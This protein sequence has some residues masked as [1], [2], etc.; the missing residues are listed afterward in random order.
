MNARTQELSDELAFAKVDFFYQIEPFSKNEEIFYEVRS[1]FPLELKSDKKENFV[2]ITKN[3]TTQDNALKEYSYLLR[4]EDFQ[5]I[6]RKYK[7]AEYKSFCEI[8]YKKTYFTKNEIKAGK[9]YKLIRD[10]AII[11]V[12][13]FVPEYPEFSNLEEKQEIYCN[14]YLYDKEKCAYRFTISKNKNFERSF[15]EGE[16]FLPC[17][18]G[19]FEIALKQIKERDGLLENFEKNNKDSF[20]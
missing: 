2:P 6:K 20:F 13:T 1:I 11:Y 4:D 16:K 7:G 12:E 5:Y 3:S 14:I 19:E 15:N 17:S 18:I 10:T 8:Y 9:I